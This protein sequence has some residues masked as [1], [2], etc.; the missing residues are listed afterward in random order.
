CPLEALPAAAHDLPPAGEDERVPRLALHVAQD[1]AAQRD[2]DPRRHRV[3]ADRVRERVVLALEADAREV[4][5][6]RHE[7]AGVVAPVPGEVLAPAAEAPARDELA[8][9]G[10]TAPHVE[11]ERARAAQRE[12]DRD[13]VART[14]ADGREDRRRDLRAED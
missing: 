5:A 14:T 11:V 3:D 6:V 9:D 2:R 1:P 10:V 4:D 12:V 8:H 7:P 13:T